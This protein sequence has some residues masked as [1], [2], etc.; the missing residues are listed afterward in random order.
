MKI[1]LNENDL[2]GIILDLQKLAD[3]KYLRMNTT[4]STRSAI[5]IYLK[6][7]WKDE[8]I[9]NYD[10]TFILVCYGLEIDKSL[11]EFLE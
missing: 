8:K 4:I 3:I 5:E 7:L 11:N 6:E 9:S 2:D 10:I 1:Y